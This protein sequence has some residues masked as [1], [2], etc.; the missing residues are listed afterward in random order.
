MAIN[1][2]NLIIDRVLQMTFEDS[3]NNLVSV[4]DQVQNVTITTSSET[5]DKNDAQGTLI[6]RFFTAKTVELSAENA[7]FSTSLAAYQYGTERE[8]A[9]AQNKI[10]MPRIL[11]IKVAD[12]TDDAVN[13]TKKYTLPEQPVDGSFSLQVCTGSGLPDTTKKF[14]LGTQASD[15]KYVIAADNTDYVLTLPKSIKSGTV[16][17]KY[18]REVESGLKLVQSADK[19]PGTSKATL[20]I[21]ASDPCDKNGEEFFAYLVFPSFQISPD[22][23]LSLNTEDAQSFSG[24]AQRDYCS[25]ENELYI[26]YIPD[27]EN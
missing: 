2:E 3:E 15:E 26:L 6:R 27:D 14:T 11:K 24:T 21:L 13:G 18:D 25:G 9:S 22:S 12:C 4:V 19:F 23:E 17:V 16:Q 8:F 7:L 5:K 20:S 1:F 10:V